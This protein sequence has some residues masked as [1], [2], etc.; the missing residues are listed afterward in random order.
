MT[1]PGVPSDRAKEAYEQVFFSSANSNESKL[2]LLEERLTGPLPGS[3][4]M[5]DACA[6]GRS[7][8]ADEDDDSDDDLRA[9][10][11]VA[12]TSKR[13]IWRERGARGGRGDAGGAG[14]QRDDV[15]AGG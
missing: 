12:E 1:P 4:T 7:R 13:R 14:R 15:A 5:S 11:V 8:A 3:G 9:F 10:G 6:A 2:K